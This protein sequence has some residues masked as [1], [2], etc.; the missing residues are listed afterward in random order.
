[1]WVRLNRPGHW[2]K[3]EFRGLQSKGSMRSLLVVVGHEFTQDRRQVLLVEHDHV[4][5]TLAAQ[6]PDDAFGDS[7]AGRHP[8]LARMATA[9]AVDRR[10]HPSSSWPVS[11]SSSSD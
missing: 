3:Q 2:P 8:E 1:H 4:I 10:A 7:V 5:Q 11:A 9:A 6:R